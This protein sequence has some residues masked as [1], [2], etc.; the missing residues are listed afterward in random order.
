MTNAKKS[1][2]LF[3]STNERYSV[4]D[5]DFVEE[6]FSDTAVI[7]GDFE[8]GRFKVAQ[9]AE[10]VESSLKSLGPGEVLVF[11]HDKGDEMRVES[12]EKIVAKEDVEESI[13]SAVEAADEV[14]SGWTTLAA[15]LIFGSV[16]FWYLWISSLPNVWTAAR[17]LQQYSSAEYFFGML[18][19]AVAVIVLVGC[20]IGFIYFLTTSPLGFRARRLQRKAL[21]RAQE[22]SVKYDDGIE[23]WDKPSNVQSV[24][25]AV[26]LITALVIAGVWLWSSVPFTAECGTSVCWRSN[27]QAVQI[28]KRSDV[29]FSQVKIEDRSIGESLSAEDVS[30]ITWVRGREVSDGYDRLVVLHGNNTEVFMRSCAIEESPTHTVW[31]EHRP[32]GTALRGF[33]IQADPSSFCPK[34]FL[35]VEEGGDN[36]E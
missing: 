35:G 36:G 33:S 25:V 16:A 1:Y 7:V 4:F 32:W 28:A 5:I 2:V 3:T 9:C 19:P 27:M 29:V 23:T 17:P 6:G 31:F 13:E 22:F 24:F 34:H 14:N 26:S 8:D 30:H 18:A 21:D 12:L 15:S 11:D 10:A 20:A